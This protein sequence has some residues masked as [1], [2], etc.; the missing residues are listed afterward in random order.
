MT[1]KLLRTTKRANWDIASLHP[2]IH[3]SL[4]THVLAQDINAATTMLWTFHF[5]TGHKIKTPK[6]QGLFVQ[7]QN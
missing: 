2:S 6:E 5:Y 3:P 7:K 4:L 1:L